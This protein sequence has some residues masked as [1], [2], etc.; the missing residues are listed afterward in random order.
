MMRRR[1]RGSRGVGSSSIIQLRLGLG[2]ELRVRMRMLRSGGDARGGISVRTM[3]H[4]IWMQIRG[5]TDGNRME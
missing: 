3:G 2:L 4:G 5:N 1:C